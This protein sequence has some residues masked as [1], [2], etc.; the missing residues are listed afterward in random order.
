MNA[1]AY[2]A[3]IDRVRTSRRVKRKRKNTT[4]FDEREKNDIQLLANNR[5]EWRERRKWQS[6]REK[7]SK[8]E[9]NLIENSSRCI[10]KGSTEL[11]CVRISTHH[12]KNACTLHWSDIFWIIVLHSLQKKWKCI[13][14]FNVLKK[15]LNFIEPMSGSLI[16]LS[17]VW[18]TGESTQLAFLISHLLLRKL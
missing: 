18:I 10:W 14:I 16:M 9:E 5:M 2:I 13:I 4:N 6:A 8:I 3:Y 7:S 15:L 12:L 11:D 17:I 1:S